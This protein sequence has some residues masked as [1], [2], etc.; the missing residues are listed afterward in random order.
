MLIGTDEAKCLREV[1]T[2][3]NGELITR[4]SGR[5]RNFGR[6]LSGV[7]PGG[8]SISAICDNMEDYRYFAACIVSSSTSEVKVYL[9]RAGNSDETVSCDSV[10]D[11]TSSK[12]MLVATNT[13]A[14]CQGG[15]LTPSF[16]GKKAYI[17]AE[18]AGETPSVV[19]VYLEGGS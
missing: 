11:E 14:V 5:Y 9:R 17:V 15:N 8:A 7:I 2:T 3:A 13:A 19:K 18:N 10:S 16:V 4:A 1:F 12:V 6:V